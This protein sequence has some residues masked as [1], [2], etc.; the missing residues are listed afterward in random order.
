MTWKV[1]ADKVLT[2]DEIT[3]VIADLKR[4]S[5]R[6][7]NTRQNLVLFR[8][9]TCCGLRASE[10]CGLSL[11]DVRVASKRPSIYVPATVAKGGK[12]RVVPLT[13]DQGTLD[14]L[15][16]WKVHRE[17]QGA[18]ATAPFLITRTGTRVDRRA[19]R[20]RYKAACRVL[21]KERVASITTHTGRHSY[22]SH[23]MQAG[24][25]PVAIRDAAGHSSLAITSIY[26]HVI[27]DDETVGNL[28]A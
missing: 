4:K 1:S 26:S 2:R 15:A 5:R 11:G 17:S 25:N 13:L 24:H 6:S 10:L 14:D 19:A 16:S 28:F 18:T 8:L 3:A 21:G 12:A 27:I 23:R 7:V 22:V 20:K 9:A